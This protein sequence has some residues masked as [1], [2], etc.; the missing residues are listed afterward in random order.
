MRCAAPWMSHPLH[1]P[2]PATPLPPWS[3]PRARAQCSF[4]QHPQQGLQTWSR[5]R[6]CRIRPAPRCKN[7]RLCT[8]AAHSLTV[9]LRSSPPLRIQH[10]ERVPSSPVRACSRHQVRK[11]RRMGAWQ[12][13]KHL[14]AMRQQRQPSTAGP[15]HP[16][17]KACERP[18]SW[19]LSYPVHAASSYC[20]A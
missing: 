3:S 9:A 20:L 7:Q 13:Q 19:L 8:G 17:L 16:S 11:G 1:Q 15:L 18:F 14:G 5:P 12:A 10:L 4:L 6:C 2:H